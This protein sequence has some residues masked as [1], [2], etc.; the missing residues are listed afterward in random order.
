M[1]QDNIHCGEIASSALSTFADKD[2]S[3]SSSFS[4]NTLA[5]RFRQTYEQYAIPCAKE[6]AAVS[7]RKDESYI[8]GPSHDKTSSWSKAI[9]W[10]PSQRRFRWRKLRD[11]SPT[12]SKYTSRLNM[13]SA[14]RVDLL[15]TV[16]VQWP[17]KDR[18]CVVADFEQLILCGI[19]K[20]GRFQRGDWPGKPRQG[21]LSARRF[22]WRADLLLAIW[23]ASTLG[24]EE[25]EEVL[26]EVDLLKQRAKESLGLE[27]PRKEPRPLTKR[28]EKRQEEIWVFRL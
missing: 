16:G 24:V 14:S 20:R 26:E 22:H 8:A 28:L 11:S 3:G 4:Q 18:K 19:Q 13:R 10:K 5:T 12:L 6:S 21:S 7:S 15:D 25:R 23:A 2:L 1:R 9:D 17:E 27:L